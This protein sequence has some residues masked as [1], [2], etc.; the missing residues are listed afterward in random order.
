MVFLFVNFKISPLV[1]YRRVL[2]YSLISL[3]VLAAIG[4]NYILNIV[5]SKI[6]KRKIVFLFFILFFLSISFIPLIFS[7]GKQYP[8]SEIYYLMQKKD[9]HNLLELKKVVNNEL[10][11]AH[12]S[13][14]TLISAMSD[15]KILADIHFIGG[16]SERQDITLFYNSNCT[17]KERIIKKYGFR[18]VYSN[19]GI[20]C[21]S[22][23]ELYS[24]G[25]FLYLVS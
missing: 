12:L 23:S 2:Y 1:P 7:Y 15:N 24:N 18:Y 16:E 3:C 25:F 5:Y 21:Q 6:G 4:L 14:S 17:E 13:Y 22:F 11:L 8:G 19:E 9:Y 20:K 10:I